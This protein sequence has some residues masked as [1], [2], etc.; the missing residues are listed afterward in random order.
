MTPPQHQTADGITIW[1]TGLP[2]AGKTTVGTEVTE[3]LRATGL[4]VEFLDG[5][6]IRK[7]LFPELGY[8]KHDRD[9]N[10]LR[11]ALLS[12]LLS[13][14]GV[15][16]VVAAIAPYRAIR[17]RIRESSANFIEVYINAAPSVCEQRDVK[18]LYRKARQGELVGFTGVDD[19]YESP[20]QPEVE[21]RTDRET[22]VESA[23]KVLE[24]VLNRLPASTVMDVR[25]RLRML[26]SQ[27]PPRKNACD[28]SAAGR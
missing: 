6:V 16:V 21:C 20:L 1:L 3:Q 15:I 12:Q 7:R 22:I 26:R 9:E 8:T 4:K 17:Q 27:P 25:N 14:N 24:C 28:S 11:L 10:V 18:G 2:S 19:P 5:D 13:R 23:E